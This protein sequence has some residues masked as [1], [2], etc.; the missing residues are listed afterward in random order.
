MWV[1]P[2]TVLSVIIYFTISHS[3]MALPEMFPMPDSLGCFTDYRLVDKQT[4]FPS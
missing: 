2:V 4:D 3:A 1:A